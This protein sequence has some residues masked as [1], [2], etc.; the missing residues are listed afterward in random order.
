VFNEPDLPDLW[1]IESRADLLLINSYQALGNIRATVPST[2]YLGGLHKTSPQP[3]PESLNRFLA[4]ASRLVYV[5]VDA[6]ICLNS[7]RL[8]K[9]LSAIELLDADI[10]WKWNG[11]GDVVNSSA[12]IHYLT[13]DTSEIDVLGKWLALY[14]GFQAENF[15]NVDKTS[16]TVDRVLEWRT[17]LY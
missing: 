4:Q 11:G 6:N 13:G 14:F 9:L 16:L 12:R 1:D 10:V 8:T 5:N 3:V 7:Y 15:N 2:V 17:V